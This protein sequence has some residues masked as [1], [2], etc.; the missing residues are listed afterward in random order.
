[1]V[2]DL[3]QIDF[4]RNRFPASRSSLFHGHVLVRFPVKNA[5]VVWRDPRDVMVSWYFHSI[6]GNSHVQPSFV[7]SCRRRSGIVDAGNVKSNMQKFVRWCFE[8]PYSPAFTWSDF[9]DYW[10]CQDCD[11]LKYE[12]VLQNPV[13]ALL[14]LE[15]LSCFS[16]DREA[17]VR[18]VVEAHS[19]AKQS[20]RRSGVEVKGAFLRKGVAGDWVNYFDSDAL[21]TL[22]SY[23]GDRMNG[24]GYT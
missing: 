17:S 14:S 15:F 21:A 13:D 7:A 9:Y 6:V 8:D 4:P 3:L 20:G 11:V 22:M 12:D 16:G 24:L 1:M 19:F 2:S 10:S 5:L 23:A 18:R